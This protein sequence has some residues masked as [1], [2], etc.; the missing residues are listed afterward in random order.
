[1]EIGKALR[2]LGRAA[3]VLSFEAAAE[4]SAQMPAQLF[5]DAPAIGRALSL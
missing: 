5:D 2:E 1:L 3:Q 4:F